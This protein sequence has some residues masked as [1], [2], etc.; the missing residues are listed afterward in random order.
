MHATRSFAPQAGVAGSGAAGTAVA[1]GYLLLSAL[2][3][4]SLFE[5][6]RLPRLTGYLVTGILAGPQVLGLVS[7]PMVENLGI[8]NGVAIALIAL[9]AGAELG[10]REMR[11]LMKGIF[12][13]IVVAVFGVMIIL[14]AAV[15]FCRGLLPFFEGLTTLQAVAVA[16]VL[17]VTMTAQ[18]PAVV[19]ALRSEMQAEGPVSRTVLGVVV[20]SDLVVIVVFALVSSLTK[21]LFG[22]S[23]DALQTA[24][25]LAWEIL[26]SAG[27]GLLA[28]LALA[29]YLKYVKGSAALFVLA[30]AFIVAEVGQRI[31]FDPLIV[32]CTAGALV[33]NATSLGHRLLEEIEGS[34]LAVY[35]VFFAV[36]GAGIHL[37]AL[38]MVGIPAAIFVLVRGMS[39]YALN[40]AAGAKAR[41]PLPVRKYAG[42]GLMPQ[43]GLALALALMFSRTFPNLGAG[44]AALVLGGVAIN[45]M[46]APILYRFAL[47]KSG[48]AGAAGAGLKSELPGP[49]ILPV[50]GEA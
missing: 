35:V 42:F 38:R 45:E 22:G 15:Y 5:S 4:G 13:V 24:G 37:D 2:F 50:E 33:R 25:R 47:V 10:L 18:S 12:W 29:V 48:E 39:F 32:A 26:G 43:A 14:P 3:A 28:G 49:A 11:P 41:A 46:V 44:A 8:F 17:G 36:T 34:S 21:T 9:T 1:G 31:D 30:V 16:A 23:A 27:A 7:R 19:I 20:L 6:L 40:W